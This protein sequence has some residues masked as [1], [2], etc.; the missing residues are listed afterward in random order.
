AIKGLGEGPIDNIIAARQGAEPFKNLFDF[1]ARTN[2]RKVNKRAI[3]A[4]IRSGSFDSLGEDRSILMGSMREAVKAAEQ[5][6]SNRDAGMADLF[7]DVVPDDEN[8]DVYAGFRQLRSWTSKQ[9]LGGEKDTLG[10]YVTGHPI[11]EYEKELRQ[12]V[13]NRIV[14]LKADK[15]T[16]KIAGLVVGLRTMKNKRGDNMAFVVLDDRSGRIE[17][18]LFS[19]AYEQYREQITKDAILVVEGV[20]T[21][22]DYSGMLKVRGKAVKTLLSARQ[23]AVRSLDLSIEVSDFDDVGQQG[24]SDQIKCLL[25]PSLSGTCPVTINYHRGD[26]RGCV[27]LGPQWQI[28]PSDDLIARLRERFGNDRVS[29]NYS[30]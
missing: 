18:S 8:G 28:Q 16:Q 25:E 17:I 7:G 23:D 1:C 12:F 24:F 11:D 13:R 4:L 10:L 21:F 6:A 22:D 26:A 30:R 19:E 9:R 5:S 20:V 29:L 15:N 14:D 2:P 27:R 3:E